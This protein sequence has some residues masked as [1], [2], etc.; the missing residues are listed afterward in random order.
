MLSTLGEIE[1]VLAAFEQS[2]LRYNE[3]K[4]A[5]GIVSRTVV[6]PLREPDSAATFL[7]VLYS[8]VRRISR[9]NLGVNVH[10]KRSFI[11]LSVHQ[12]FENS[13]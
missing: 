13:Q 7:H 3:S 9:E 6:D 4:P 5:D 12:F 1:Y 11:G 10:F 8:G 2:L